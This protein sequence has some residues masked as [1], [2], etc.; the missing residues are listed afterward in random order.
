MNLDVILQQVHGYKDRQRVRNDCYNVLNKV[1]TLIP[2]LGKQVMPNGAQCNIVV[3]SGTVEI[4]FRGAHY[5]VPVEIFLGN[6]YPFHPPKVFV[7]P[8]KDM[9]IKPGHKHVD[10]E[11]VVYLPYLHEWE[12][13]YHNLVDLC[14][15]T[16]AVFSQAPPMYAR[17]TGQNSSQRGVES[18]THTKPTESPE[19]VAIQLLSQKLQI[20]LNRLYHELRDDIDTEFKGQRKIQRNTK[21][22]K[23][24]EEELNSEIEKLEQLIEL[25]ADKKGMIAEAKTKQ[26]QESK[27]PPTPDSYV[28]PAD[29]YSRQVLELVAE[30]A[31]IDDT[32]YYLDRSFADGTSGMHLNAFLREVGRLSRKAFECRALLNKVREIQFARNA[33]KQI[34]AEFTFQHQH[35]SSAAYNVATT[36]T[37]WNNNIG[38]NSSQYQQLQQPQYQ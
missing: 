13:Q 1:R 10:N 20:E 12:A 6:T 27:E 32:L 3:L 9:E 30:N 14:R 36:E 4:F 28:V 8:T 23:D 33:Q 16:S 34:E 26:E 15:E 7:R 17:R 22:Q 2:K 24:Q 29:V 11:G 37:Q 25:A 19:K 5:N 38:T 21:T 31:A 18:P 35:L